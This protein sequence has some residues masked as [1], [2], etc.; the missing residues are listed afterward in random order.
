MVEIVSFED[1]I[2]G[3][4]KQDITEAMSN[5]CGRWVSESFLYLVASNS[6]TPNVTFGNILENMLKE[7]TIEK[8]YESGVDKF[9]RVVH[10]PQYRLVINYSDFNL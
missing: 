9:D 6:T 4:I 2:V 10:L 8:S 1:K 5:R 3:K 7:G